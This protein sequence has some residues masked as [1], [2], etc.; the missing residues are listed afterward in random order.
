M[1][2]GMNLYLS[3]PIAGVELARVL[4]AYALAPQRPRTS[5]P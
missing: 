3:K 5:A 4:E 1:D 2:A